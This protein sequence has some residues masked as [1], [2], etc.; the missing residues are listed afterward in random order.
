MERRFVPTEAQRLAMEAAYPFGSW[1]LRQ[2]GRDQWIGQLATF[3]AADPR[4][5]RLGTDEEVRRRI[6][7][8]A[9]DEDMCGA[10]YEALSEW[11]REI[12]LLATRQ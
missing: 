9:L 5:P 2:R 12:K 6:Q 1:L 8:Q 7:S 4:F 11:R 3:A 10:L